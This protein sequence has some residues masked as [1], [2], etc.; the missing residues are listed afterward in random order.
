MYSLGDKLLHL[1]PR[2]EETS[3]IEKNTVCVCIWQKDL[4]E[5]QER[6]LSAPEG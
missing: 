5:L 4:T 1:L 3:G 2:N 6:P